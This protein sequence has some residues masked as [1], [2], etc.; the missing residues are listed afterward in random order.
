MKKIM[1]VLAG[2]LLSF[3]IMMGS[4]LAFEFPEG[5]IELDLDNYARLY[6]EDGSLVPVGEA[7]AVG[8]VSKT[9]L[10]FKDISPTLGL[11]GP[12][13]PPVW[14]AGTNDEY[15]YGVIKNIAIDDVVSPTDP[16]K[17]TRFYFNEETGAT[18]YEVEIYVSSIDLT[19]FLTDGN[20]LAA[21]PDNF[22][23]IYA[24]LVAN[25][26]LILAGDYAQSSFTDVELGL[27]LADAGVE[28]PPTFLGGDYINQ[29]TT[30][31]GL[32]V[33]CFVDIDPNVGLGEYVIQGLYGS[34]PDVSQYDIAVQNIRLY[35]ESNEYEWIVSDDGVRLGIAPPEEPGDCRVTAGGNK[36]VAIICDLKLNGLPDHNCIKED[37]YHTWGGQAGAGPNFDPNVNWIHHYKESNKDSFV[38]HCNDKDPIYI[39]CS[40]AGDFCFPARYAPYRQIDF[41]SIGQFNNKKG[42]EDNPDL[43]DAPVGVP[44]CFEVHLEDLGEPGPGSKWPISGLDC[45]H[46]PGTQILNGDPYDLTSRSDCRDCTDY[47]A[48]KIYDDASHDAGTG[49]CTG[50]LLWKNGE[51]SQNCTGGII[52]APFVPYEGFNIRAGNVQMH[53]DN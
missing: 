35:S 23:I 37:I 38:F 41:V 6:N 8:M 45:E 48:I 24:N 32:G 16:T 19:T 40:D 33:N 25:S 15:L 46:C 34:G 49:R 44:L 11:N 13:L 10:I 51:E 28:V 20:Y 52:V 53:P 29:D 50:S 14:V 26:T 3:I 9:F 22:D 36:D 27:V 7:P 43:R 42:F 2:C 17:D 31:F 4:A 21:G 39:M 47:Y 18:G 1:L 12:D 30:P 5:P